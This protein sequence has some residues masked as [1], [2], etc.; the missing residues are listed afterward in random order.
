V[1]PE[2]RSDVELRGTLQALRTVARRVQQLTAE[3]RELA[4]EIETL[5]ESNEVLHLCT[6]PLE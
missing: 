4:G 2:R 6:S 3:E 1:R 5:I